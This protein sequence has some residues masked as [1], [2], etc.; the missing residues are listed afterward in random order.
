[1]I[2]GLTT[3]GAMPV[4][5]RLVQFTQA[6]HQVLVNNIANL[7]T[8]YFKPHDLSVD[9]FQA[10]LRE[11]IEQRRR[12]PNSTG[13]SLNMDDNREMRFTSG[14]IEVNP[15]YANNNILFHDQNNRDLERLMQN[16]AEN[17][18]VHRTSMEL[19]R[20]EVITLQT[21]IRERV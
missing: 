3:S 13:S 4:L 18:I 9:S 12:T 17:T 10:T 11:A 8:P 21:A 7:S 2:E 6:R 20:S 15:D 1:M 19:L 5:Q 16:L 14:G